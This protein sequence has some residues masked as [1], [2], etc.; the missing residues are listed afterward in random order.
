[1]YYDPTGR[2]RDE[3]EEQFASMFWNKDD[4][5]E[6]VKL[7]NNFEYYNQMYLDSTNTQDKISYYEAMNRAKR[8]KDELRKSNNKQGEYNYSIENEIDGLY[9]NEAYRFE[10]NASGEFI[11]YFG[12]TNTVSSKNFVGMQNIN[13]NVPSGSNNNINNTIHNTNS[14]LSGSN[15]NMNSINSSGLNIDINIDILKGTGIGLLRNPLAGTNY[16]VNNSAVY[17]STVFEIAN[18][19][20]YITLKNGAIRNRPI[21]RVDSPHARYNYNHINVEKGQVSSRLFKDYNH[22]RISKN[23]FNVAKNYKTV[24]KTAKYA[25]RGLVAVS[26]AYDAYDIYGAYMNDGKTIGKETIVTTSGV[27]GSWGGSIAGAKAG[28]TGGALIGTMIFPGPGTMIGGF[29]GGIGG[30]IAGGIAGRKAGEGIAEA[31]L[32]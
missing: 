24:A 10:I 25:G 17:G 22:K 2:W 30:G 27:A 19:F 13:R 18:R 9:F 8:K 3:I 7:V 6:M 11:N 29:I 16:F 14:T 26:V 28:G 21:F 32:K 1:M 15:I 31:M 4:Y 23:T 5:D 20:D 12:Q